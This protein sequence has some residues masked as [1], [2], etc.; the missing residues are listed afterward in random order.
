[1]LGLGQ[2]VRSLAPIMD[3]FVRAASG[4]ARTDFWKRIYNPADAYGGEVVT[5]WISRFYP[6]LALEGTNGAPNPMLDLRLGEPRGERGPGIRT[7]TVP[8]TLCRAIINVKDLGINRVVALDAGLTGVAQDPD[9]ALRPVAGWALLDAPPDIET[10]IDRLIA[11]HET[12]PPETAPRG[13]SG[14]AEMLAL[15]NRIASASLFDGS[16]RLLPYADMVYRDLGPHS[17]CC[18]FALADGRY[19]GEVQVWNAVEPQWAVLRDGDDPAEVPL[20]GTSLAHLLD[21]A[22]DAD[23]DI[24]HLE[25][26]RLAD[27]V[28]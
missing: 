4:D 26:G 21:A 8:A 12:T 16:W 19:V 24:A 27:L 20:L 7:D 15:H 17:I 2:W 11:E 1:M 23:G 9:G 28:L 6:Y 14:G 3:E 5:G 22:M 13:L 25:V 18:W 10:V